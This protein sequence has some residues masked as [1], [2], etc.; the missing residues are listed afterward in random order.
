LN[1]VNSWT[2]QHKRTPCL[3]LYMRFPPNHILL[4][5]KPENIA[6]LLFVEQARTAQ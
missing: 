5:K 4:F 3:V 1:I 2:E 6:I